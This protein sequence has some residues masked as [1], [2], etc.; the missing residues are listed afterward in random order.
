MS[1]H[2]K[3]FLL[4]ATAS[5]ISLID[6]LNVHDTSLKAQITNVRAQKQKVKMN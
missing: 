3:I 2:F 5:F 6:I 1:V 4:A